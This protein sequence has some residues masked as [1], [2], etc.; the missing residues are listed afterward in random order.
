MSSESGTDEEGETLELTYSYKVNGK[1][2]EGCDANKKR[3]IRRKAEKIFLKNGKAWTKRKMNGMT[4]VSAAC[5]N[6]LLVAKRFLSTL[7]SSLISM[8]VGDK[9]MTIESLTLSHVY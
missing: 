4:K 2:P 9:I 7:W 3:S 5:N 8:V 6:V 1:Y